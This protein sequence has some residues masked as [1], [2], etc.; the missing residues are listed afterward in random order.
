[1]RQVINKLQV[2]N[3][4]QY[5]Y[6]GSPLL[7]NK[8]TGYLFSDDKAMDDM[9]NYFLSLDGFELKSDKKKET[10]KQTYKKEDKSPKKEPSKPQQP[11]KEFIKVEE[12][13]I[14]EEPVVE[15][16]KEDIKEEE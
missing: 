10:P 4:K 2:R 1:M 16:V 15:E 7:F 6:K 13:V 3:S 8:V 5:F 14:V 12:K 9:V 11:K